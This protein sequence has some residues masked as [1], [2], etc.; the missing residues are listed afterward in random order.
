MLTENKFI[1]LFILISIFL[2]IL[3]AS[4]IVIVDPCFH[5]HKPFEFFQYNLQGGKER[6]QNDGIGKNWDYDAIITGSSMTE[7][8]K[9]TQFDDLFNVSSVK[10]PFSGSSWKEINDNLARALNKKH[11]KAIVRGLDTNQILNDKDRQRYSGFP[12]YLY[13]NLIFDDVN[14]VLNKNF[15][16]DYVIPALSYTRDGNKTTSFDVYNNWNAGY[17]FGAEAVWNSYKDSRKN[18][19]LPMKEFSDDDKIVV[20][21]NVNQNVLELVALY[22]DVQFYYFFTPYSIMWWDSV[23]QD[24]TMFQITEG[25]KSACTLLLKH[26]NLHL[27]SF[28]DDYEMICN[29]DNYKDNGHYGEW[30]NEWMLECMKNDVS[31]LNVSTYKQY[32]DEIFDFYNNYDYEKLITSLKE[33]Y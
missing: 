12:E 24:G 14:Y 27:F 16:F 23:K 22:P 26:E 32:W 7:N 18:D 9:T 33:N 25:L 8:F 13:N 4:I 31:R 29:L 5:Y 20:R 21:D 1:K 10:L 19:A 15:M 3:F 6:Y 17:T 2:M 30:V 28:F 11:P